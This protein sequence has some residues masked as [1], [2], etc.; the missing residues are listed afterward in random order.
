LFH[1][2]LNLCA[3]L[4]VPGFIVEFLLKANYIY[5]MLKYIYKFIPPLF[6]ACAI[7]FVF[8]PQKSVA[9]DFT[10]APVRI[11]F[12][13]G[14]T[15]SILTITNKSENALTLQLKSFTWEQDEEGK[16]VYSPTEDII[17][18]PKIFKIGKDEEKLVR[19]GTKILHGS[20]EKTY[21]LFMEEVPE[22]QQK[23]KG[24][25]VKILMRVGVPIFIVP[26]QEEAKG[27]IAGAVV[28]NGALTLT[29]KNEGNSHFIIKK[30]TAKGINDGGNEVFN[31]ET[32][33]GY[34]HA[35]NAKSFKI[36]LPAD[37]CLEAK[38]LEITIATD[39]LSMNEKIEIS[40]KMCRY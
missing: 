38:T 18:F 13:S 7:Y 32:G 20:H 40:K 6:M 19:L 28:Q 31:T 37:D 14:T 2:P 36:E 4:Y 11:F 16:D 22:P 5:S 9:A 3:A 17:F 39:K 21:R 1:A 25:A 29:V 26:L 27:S 24:A 15:T 12:D 23:A 10:I 33:G 8:I 30:I 34:L 35:G